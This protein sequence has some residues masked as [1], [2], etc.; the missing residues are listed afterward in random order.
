MRFR[1]GKRRKEDGGGSRRHDSGVVD[2][3]GDRKGVAEEGPDAAPLEVALAQLP[4]QATCQRRESKYSLGIFLRC[5]SPASVTPVP[6]RSRPISSVS[7][8]SSLMPSSEVLV[9]LRYRF[10]RCLMPVSSFRPRSVMPVWSK[11]KV[12]RCSNWP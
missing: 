7:P 2:R 3:K 10:W 11:F 8:V 5:F 6:L 4:F 12:S 9:R 1:G